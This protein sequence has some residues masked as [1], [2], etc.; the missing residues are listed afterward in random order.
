MIKVS[1]GI[2][3]YYLVKATRFTFHRDPLSQ[4]KELAEMGILNNER[5]IC[6]YDQSLIDF[7]NIYYIPEEDYNEY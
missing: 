7:D 3:F 6:I 4:H 2:I 5:Q 1:R